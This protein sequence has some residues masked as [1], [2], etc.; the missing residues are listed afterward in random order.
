MG[1]LRG[2]VRIP[3][4]PTPGPGWYASPDVPGGAGMRRLVSV[5]AGVAAATA[6]AAA[7]AEPVVSLKDPAGDDN[8]PGAYTYPT[9]AV[10]KPGSFDILSFDVDVKG[11]DVVFKVGVRSKIEDPWDSKAWQGNGFSLQF[12]QV[13]IDTDRKDGSGTCEGLPGMNVRFRSA[14][15]WEKV[16]LVSPQPKSRLQSEIGQKAAKMKAGVVIPTATR[17]D[18]KTLVATVKASDLGGKPAK[19]WGYAVPLQSN[20][21]YPDSKEVLTRKVNEYAGQHRF[22]GGSDYACDPHVI[23]MIVAPGQGGADEVRMQHSALKY[24]CDDQDKPKVELPM[25]YP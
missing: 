20:E 5:I 12:V 15:C 8:G 3:W 24:S 22:G 19:G 10:Y 16:V 7:I 18:G 6:A 25:V 11:S 23:D 2:F 9:D 14:S 21:G 1:S 13:Y 17:V 4:L